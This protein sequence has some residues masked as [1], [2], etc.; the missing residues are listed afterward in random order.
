[1]R[2]HIPL[3]L[4]L[5][6]CGPSRTAF[7]EEFAATTCQK[8]SECYGA[9]GLGLLGYDSVE[10][11]VTEG[12][13]DVTD[14]TDETSCPDYNREQATTCLEELAAADCDDIEDVSA[15]CDEVCPS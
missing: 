10:E 11:C 12:T 9:A 8:L 1:M 2:I 6:A 7:S 15:A 13:T 14:E 5:A 4:L 3:A